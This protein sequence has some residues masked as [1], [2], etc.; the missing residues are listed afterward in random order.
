M[1][2][3]AK[4]TAMPK[5]RF[6]EF[7][8][9]K[10]WDKECL[11]NLASEALSNGVF[12][13]PKKIGSGYKLINVLDMYIGTAI[14]ESKLSLL[15]LKE[16]DFKKNKVEHGDIFFTR[17]SLVKE[18]IAYSNIYLGASDD[19]TFDG[20]LIRFR[21]NKSIINPLFVNYILKTEAVRKQLVARGKT[22]TMTTIGQSDVADVKIP[23][24]SISEQKKIADCLT[25][26]DEVIAVQEQK[27]EALK[28]HKRG[29]MQQLFPR[30][31]D[32]LPRL[33]FPGFR[34]TK[35]W[36]KEYLLNLASEALS[37]GVFNDPNKVGSG[38]RLI[39]VSDM[40]IGTVIDESKLSLLA[41]EEVDFKKNKVEN[42]DIFFTRSSLVKEGIAYSN[43]YL[44]ASEDITFDGHLIRFRPNKNIVNPLFANYVLKTEAVRKQL[45]AR[46]KTATMTTIGQS[47]VATVKIPVPSISEQQSITNCLVSFDAQVTAESE[48]LDALKLYKKGMM[49]Q[50]FPNPMEVKE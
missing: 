26:L 19:V 20:H 49:Q 24:P 6:P 27:V 46:G 35:A 34:D 4:S 47:D 5:L 40:Y 38:Y 14:D 28:I 50:L 33:R 30:E 42:G 15:A 29:L 31:D 36:N 25:S 8:E 3:D 41:L 43:V 23:V 13:D 2:R 45:V 21:P 44:G 12:N 9:A 18:G 22:A 48:N 17:S 39:N 7:R 10:A 11:L 37:N 16:A 1:A 32:P